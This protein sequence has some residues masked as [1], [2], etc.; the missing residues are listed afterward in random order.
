MAQNAFG[1]PDP[2]I[3]DVSIDRAFGAPLQA[4]GNLTYLEFLAVVKALWEN[5]HPEV[6]LKPDHGGAYATYP[7]VIY[8]L[9][10][11]KAHTTEPKPRNRPTVQND[12][13]VFGQRFQNV[14]SFTIVTKADRAST[15]STQDDGKY[16][17]AEVA[18]AL[19]EIF[20]D[21]MLEYTPVFKR[22]GASEFV[23]ARRLADST[24]TR[25]NIDVCKRTIT[26][27]LTTEKLIQTSVS[28]IDKIAI[29]IR[30]AMS[31]EAGLI[32]SPQEILANKATPDYSD[33]PVQ[34][35]DLYSATPSVSGY[36]PYAI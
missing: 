12:R 19:A 16:V 21:F 15:A 8:G 13:M 35:V 18:D 7:A 3:N 2:R 9:E 26:Y 31:Y 17:G 1:F 23:Y 33:T 36:F 24:E 34:I 11:R 28:V 5:I 10:I 32:T 4:N 14:V 25:S 27:M 30:T 29:D 22:L 6:P 20:E